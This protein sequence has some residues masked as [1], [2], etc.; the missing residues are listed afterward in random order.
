MGSEVF[1]RKWRPQTL[2]EVVG[3]EPVTQTLRHAVESG[4]IAHAYL[5]CGP[6][7]TG[8]TS[9]ARILAKAVNCPEQAGGEPCNACDMCRSIAEGRALDVIEI[10]AASNR[11][12]DEIRS[13]RE[14]AN[15]A[16]SL[17]R[18]KVY[19]IDEVH[20]LT[21]AA[22]NALLKTLEEPPPHVIFVL[23]TTEAHK[24]ITTI[25]SRCQR[26]NFHRLRQVEIM[27]KLKLICKKEGIQIEPGALELIAR[28][29]TGSLRDAEN[30]LQQM[31]AYYGSQIELDQIQAE[32]GVSADSRVRQ[33]AQ[34]VVNRDTTAGLRIINSLNSDGVDLRQF[35][36]GLVEYLRGLLLAKSRCEEALDFAGEDLAEINSLAADAPLDY[37]LKAVKSFSSIDF[38]SDNYS[39][40]SLEL[41]LLGCV[42][43]PPTGQEQPT[44]TRSSHLPKPRAAGKP[45]AADATNTV[46][47][48]EATAHPAAPSSPEVPCEVPEPLDLDRVGTDV[49]GKEIPQD[50]DYLRGRW[51]DFIRSLRGEGSS[52]N[53]DA[54]LRSACDPIDLE[55]DTLVLGFR[56]PFHKEKIE[57]GKY[58]HLVEKKLKEVFGRPYKIRCILVDFK[59]EVPSRART[60]NPVIKAALE[61]GAK[62]SEEELSS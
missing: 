59:R 23:A 52:G 18:Y 53:L 25:I 45:E 33:L 28:A 42:L 16:P 5:F 19:I 40:L 61:M 56:Y 30:I 37:L 11:G 32:L 39:A 4:K 21:E 26:F 3:Q 22:C 55:D 12:I 2:S 46:E 15:Y 14:K 44:E 58:R 48:T 8:K 24:V 50:I 9:M 47:C 51:R 62:I 27:D 41:A 1:Y 29:A 43:S 57:D 20:M 10:D 6:R 38:R 34:C 36:M 54:F 17:A 31:I 60:T 35:N 7:G 13:L 49:P